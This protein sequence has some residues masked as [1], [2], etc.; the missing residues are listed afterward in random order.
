MLLTLSHGILHVSQ[1]NES[2]KILKSLFWQAFYQVSNE[3]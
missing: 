2:Q 1:F 3:I